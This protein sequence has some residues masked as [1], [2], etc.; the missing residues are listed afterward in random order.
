[1]PNTYNCQSTYSS[2]INVLE[3]WLCHLS[4]LPVRRISQLPDCVEP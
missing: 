1:M 2:A 4:L 3:H